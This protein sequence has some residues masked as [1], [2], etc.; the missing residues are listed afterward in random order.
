MTTTENGNLESVEEEPTRG[1]AALIE[2][3]ECTGKRGGGRTGNR[4][5]SPVNVAHAILAVCER[6]MTAKEISYHAMFLGL[7]KSEAAHPVNSFIHPVS[8]AIKDDPNCPIT[9][10]K[11][12]YFA[13]AA[14]AP[15]PMTITTRH[16]VEPTPAAFYADLLATGK[17]IGVES[18][19][20]AVT[21]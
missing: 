5:C 18:D 13:V 2:Q 7:W 8:T 1:L 17:L 12:G 15:D 6:P 19:L 11:S 9:R 4:A 14:G 21:D 10:A 16:A 20:I 3:F